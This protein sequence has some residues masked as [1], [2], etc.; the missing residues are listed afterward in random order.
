MRVKTEAR[1]E[2][3][4]EKAREVFRDQGFERASMSEIAARVGGSKATLY[5][6]FK[7]KEELFASVMRTSPEVGGIFDALV[8]PDLTITS[9][10][11]FREIV[12]HFAIAYLNVSLTPD[13]LAAR[14]N[15]IA[16][17]EVSDA[18]K[19]AFEAG[20]MKSLVLLTTFI[21]RAIREGFLR[22]A[23]PW[24]AMIHLLS[25]IEAEYLTRRLFG[26]IPTPPPEEIRGAALRAV[27]AY[28][29]AYAPV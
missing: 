2:A 21:D 25:L 15:F 9:P 26:L 1:R 27:D 29:R 16:I 7:S 8:A 19:R 4:L 22:S 24:V 6:Y 20:P 14:R 23:E 11:H 13:V 3:I 18:G 5:S 28:L 17:A 10:Q 12:E